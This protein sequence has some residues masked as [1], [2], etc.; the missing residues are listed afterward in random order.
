MPHP[1]HVTEWGDH[2]ET[3][4]A[5]EEALIPPTRQGAKVKPLRHVLRL[6]DPKQNQY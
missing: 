6:F 2:K 5:A 4:V 1:A 3:S